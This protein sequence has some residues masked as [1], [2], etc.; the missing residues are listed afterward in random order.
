MPEFF[1]DN[2]GK[3]DLNSPFLR[4]KHQKL[5]IELQDSC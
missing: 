2:L 5:L 1:L 3:W 4:F